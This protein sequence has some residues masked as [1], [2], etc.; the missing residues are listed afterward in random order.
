MV[1]EGKA[2]V[3]HF[4]AAGLK[5]LDTIIPD[6]GVWI[7]TYEISL[8]YQMGKGW[9]SS[10]VKALFEFLYQ[11]YLLAPNVSLEAGSNGI[12]FPESKC[13]DLTFREYLAAKM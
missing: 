12:E 2:E 9:G 5:F 1:V 8:D 7:T 6:L 10:Q 3:F 13:L 11:T 4:V